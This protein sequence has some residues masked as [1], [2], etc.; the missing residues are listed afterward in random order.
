MRC[1]KQAR[2]WRLRN[3]TPP[4][5]QNQILDQIQRYSRTASNLVV[6]YFVSYYHKLQVLP[7]EDSDLFFFRISPQILFS[8]LENYKV[9]KIYLYM[10]A[11]PNLLMYQLTSTTKHFNSFVI[12]QKSYENYLKPENSKVNLG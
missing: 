2:K 11:K 6:V 7:F 8:N 12:S 3:K 4:S 9:K 5:R 1:I 10:M